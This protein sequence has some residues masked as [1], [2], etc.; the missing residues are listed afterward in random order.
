MADFLDGGCANAHCQGHA[1]RCLQRGAV[2]PLLGWT[3]AGQPCGT[4]AI[5]EQNS[6]LITHLSPQF[7]RKYSSWDFFL[8]EL[9]E[10]QKNEAYFLFIC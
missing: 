5:V 1:G 6:F 2:G 8:C 3:P 4:A 7:N 10:N 9:E